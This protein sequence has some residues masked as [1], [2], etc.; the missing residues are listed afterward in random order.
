MVKGLVS[1]RGLGG[2]G[3]SGVGGGVL[4]SLAHRGQS[5]LQAKHP[6]FQQG[7][8]HVRTGG[9]M[10]EKSGRLDSLNCKIGITRFTL[11]GSYKD[12]MTQEK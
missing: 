11:R 5:K 9:L 6:A 7:P 12:E 3:W 8:H 2:W 10:P 4:L 1:L